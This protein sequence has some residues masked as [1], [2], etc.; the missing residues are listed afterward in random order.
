VVTLVESEWEGYKIIHVTDK[1]T[2]FTSIDRILEACEFHKILRPG[3]ELE[4]RDEDILISL[5]GDW[6]IV[7]GEEKK[8]YWKK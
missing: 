2:I 7:P 4:I 3:E 8:M 1:D 5:S 6:V